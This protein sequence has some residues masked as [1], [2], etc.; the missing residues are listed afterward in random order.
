[1]RPEHGLGD[2]G[3]A[4][5]RRLQGSAIK[6]GVVQVATLQEEEPLRS[7]SKVE[8]DVSG[9]E[10][11]RLEHCLA[12][13]RHHEPHL[14]IQIRKEGMLEEERRVHLM[15]QLPLEQLGHLPHES[16][17]ARRH[18]IASMFGP[19]LD[20]FDDAQPEVKADLLLPEIASQ[21]PELLH[22]VAFHVPQCRHRSGDIRD[23]RRE[24][25]HGEE[26]DKDREDTFSDV[27]R[28]HVHGRR[29]ELSQAPV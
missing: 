9:G 12:D 2:P 27:D 24:G 19:M 3:L 23:N 25:H 29:R 28:A 17:A 20:E 16:D 8:D 5:Q 1:M 6:D 18:Q 22:L 7:V 14:C 26:E 4:L 15:L 21:E 11:D 13:L 10:A